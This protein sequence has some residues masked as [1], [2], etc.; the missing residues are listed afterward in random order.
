MKALVVYYSRTGT[1]KKVA[2]AISEMLKCDIEGIVDI[3]NRKGILGFLGAGRD[4]VF[5]KLT[6][7]NDVKKGPSEY[8]LVLIGTPIWVG[9]MSV[10]IRTYLSKYKG[11][12]K[13][14]AFFCTMGG[15]GNKRAFKNMEELIG[16]KSESTLVLRDREIKGDYIY[17]IKEFVNEINKIF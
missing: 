7:I 8:D 13:R 5:N 4:T 9:N 10:A 6:S 15:S 16:K 1:T 2:E 12:F 3:K 17:R 11:K 14:V